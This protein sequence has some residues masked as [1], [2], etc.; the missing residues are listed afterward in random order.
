MQLVST[1]LGLR[2]KSSSNTFTQ[3]GFGVIA[4]DNGR[5]GVRD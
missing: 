1:L 2:E 3:C 4:E 5:C